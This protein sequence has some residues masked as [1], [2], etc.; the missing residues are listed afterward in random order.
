MGKSNFIIT[1]LGNRRYN[2]CSAVS[3]EEFLG[4][5]QYNFDQKW[6]F[7]RY[8]LRSEEVLRLT[9][10]EMNYYEYQIEMTFNF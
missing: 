2:S 4:V 3:F 7:H 8:I 1:L 5:F 10:L 9:H 6:K